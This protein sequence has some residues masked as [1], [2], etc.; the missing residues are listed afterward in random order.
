MVSAA[1]T[2]A[3][4]KAANSEDWDL[5]KNFKKVDIVEGNSAGKDKKMSREWTK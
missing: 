5:G 2:G 4:L 3:D 1:A